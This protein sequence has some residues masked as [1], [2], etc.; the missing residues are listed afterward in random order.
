MY[1]DGLSFGTIDSDTIGPLSPGEFRFVYYPTKSQ[2]EQGQN[3]VEVKGLEDKVGN[4][5]NGGTG[6]MLK[7]ESFNFP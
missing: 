2:L 7:T 3:T 4:F 6:E 5:E 1:F